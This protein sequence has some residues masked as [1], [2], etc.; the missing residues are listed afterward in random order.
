M[1]HG[2][3]TFALAGLALIIVACAEQSNRSVGDPPPPPAPAAAAPVEPPAAPSL[4][5]TAPPPTVG[6]G[7]S[8]RLP[9]LVIHTAEPKSVEATGKICL[10]DGILEF[11]AVEVG[12][13][14]YESLLTLETKPSALK[15]ALLLIGCEPGP[16]PRET[17]PGGKSGDRL[18]IQIEWETDG[19]TKRVPAEQLLLDRRTKQPARDIEWVFTGSHFM[20]DFEGREAF[21]SDLE[22]AFVALWHQPTVMINVGGDYGNPYRDDQEGFDINKALAPP[23]GTPVKLIFGKHPPQAAPAKD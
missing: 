1:N 16:I 4:P 2:K 3:P 23:V 7:E 9:G 17:P 12:G 14:D 11:L 6:P 5:P 15:F 20:K 21:A 22:E 18:A 8:V 13:R 10:E 19:V